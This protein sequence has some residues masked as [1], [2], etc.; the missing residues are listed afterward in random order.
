MKY[1]CSKIFKHFVQLRQM[2]VSKYFVRIFTL[3]VWTWLNLHIDIIIVSFRPNYHRV[4]SIGLWIVVS[5]VHLLVVCGRIQV[6]FSCETLL[7]HIGWVSYAVLRDIG[8]IALLS[9]NFLPVNSLK[10]LVL[11][12]VANLKSDIGVGDQYFPH[13]VPRH[14]IQVLWKNNTPWINHFNYLLRVKRWHATSVHEAEILSDSNFHGF[15]PE[16]RKTAK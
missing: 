3:I 11:H 8:W 15:G 10:E 12:N 5:C 13:D 9:A 1:I 16:W 2:E 4:W 14:W 6:N 7:F